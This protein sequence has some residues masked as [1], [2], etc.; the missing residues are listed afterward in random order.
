M[1][2]NKIQR[3]KVVMATKSNNPISDLV[4]TKEI[5][6]TAISYLKSKPENLIYI[7]YIFALG[8][9]ESKTLESRNALIFNAM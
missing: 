9:V 1:Y 2:K 3:S 8:K 6:N 7:F 4:K 5:F